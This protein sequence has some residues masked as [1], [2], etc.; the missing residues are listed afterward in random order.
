MH[1]EA[2]NDRTLR[3]IVALLVSLAGLAEQ[4]AGRCAPVRFLILLV[5]RPAEAAARDYVADAMLVDG[6][7]FDDGMDDASGPLA[8]AL[9]GQR[10]RLLAAELV[11]LLPAG[12]P[13]GARDERTGGRHGL[14]PVWDRRP[15]APGG[16]CV[17]PHD[18][19]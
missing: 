13:S 11:A 1:G 4:A 18:T 16:L 19:S 12:V 10:F 9:L 2:R 15:V 14:S 7:W 6:L 17:E 5:L 8:A 3:R